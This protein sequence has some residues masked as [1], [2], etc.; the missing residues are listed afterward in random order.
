MHYRTL[1][2]RRGGN[3]HT[4]S[5]HKTSN[6]YWIIQT[7]KRRHGLG[8][9]D[10]VLNFFLSQSL[11]DCIYALSCALTHRARACFEQLAR[12]SSSGEPF[13]VEPFFGVS[14]SCS[15]C[16]LSV[17]LNTRQL[18]CVNM[19][20]FWRCVDLQCVFVSMNRYDVA[21]LCE[22]RLL[23][24]FVPLQCVPCEYI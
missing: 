18:C 22:M 5:R 10:V 24:R 7:K 16:A 21:V 23:W 19:S 2:A 13:G 8:P 9:L 6:Q 4:K 11:H 14:C 12:G 1:S 20:S 17:Y 3:R 15:A